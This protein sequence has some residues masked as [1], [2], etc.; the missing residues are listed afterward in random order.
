MLTRETT[1]LAAGVCIALARCPRPSAADADV[2][3][4]A[5]ERRI[6]AGESGPVNTIGR[7]LRGRRP[8]SALA[9]APHERPAVLGW[10]TLT[11]TGARSAKLR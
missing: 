7:R 2:T 5:N 11:Q 8:S 9:T 6:V 1:G 4:D 10:Q 3:S